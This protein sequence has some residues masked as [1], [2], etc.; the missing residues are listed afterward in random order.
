MPFDWKNPLGYSIA[1]V[2]QL[3]IVSQPLRFIGCM[4][5]I[6]VGGYYFGW[7]LVNEFKNETKSYNEI[8]NGK[9]SRLELRTQLCE[10][11]RFSYVKR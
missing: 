4:M 9:A 8:I 7:S 6:G 10:R 11:I 1:I 3:L 2:F 5:S